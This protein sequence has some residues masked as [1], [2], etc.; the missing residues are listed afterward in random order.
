MDEKEPIMTKKEKEKAAEE[1]EAK[2]REM[3]KAEK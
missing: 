3:L 1:A 2:A